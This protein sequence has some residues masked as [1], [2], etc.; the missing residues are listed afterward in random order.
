VEAIDGAPPASHP[1][2]YA[3]CGDSPNDEPM[4]GAF[5]QTFAVAN[6]VRF[7]A[8]MR[9]HPAWVSRQEGGAGFAEVVD[10]LLQARRTAGTRQEG[11]H[12]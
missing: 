10:A 7:L 8:E 1:A 6:V 4:F 11:P 12:T 3:F 2:A 5:S 9:H